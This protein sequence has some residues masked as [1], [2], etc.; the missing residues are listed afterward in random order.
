[1]LLDHGLIVDIPD[2]LRQQYC[3]LWCSFV[4]NDQATAA[5]V[6]TQIA[7]QQPLRKQS[8][9]FCKAVFMLSGYQ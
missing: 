3:Q 8:Q 4:L 9:A 5:A 6:A 2:A 1:M 7:G